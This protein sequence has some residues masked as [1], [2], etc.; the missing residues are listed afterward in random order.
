MAKKKSEG[1]GEMKRR[2]SA[3]PVPPMAEARVV[4]PAV[5]RRGGF[6]AIYDLLVWFA[7]F[8]VAQLCAAAVVMA[9]GLG[10]HEGGEPLSP[11]Q[12]GRM[13]ALS[14][15][16]SYVLALIFMLVYRRL[17]GGKG[18]LVR[19]SARGFDPLFL[20][21]GVVFMLAVGVVL[22]PL[23]ALLPA[24]PS[25]MYGTGF[26]TILS[27]VVLAPLFEE[28]ICRGV[29]LESLR[30]RFGVVGAW[31]LSSLFFGAIHLQPQL[32][33]NAL[34]MGMI[35]GYVVIRTGSLWSAILLHAINNS[36]AYVALAVGLDH[37]SLSDL[38]QDPT[39]YGLIYALCALI[40][41][42]SVT[43]AGRV[44][45]RLHRDEREKMAAAV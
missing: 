27:V 45:R 42:V 4:E 24:V 12:M 9:L 14:G 29:V 3:V 26:W 37:V 35:L 10:P 30:G 32:S 15:G 43:M 34:F 20:L 23:L 7:L 41:L 36:M 2:S 17:R 31:A 39:L 19:L 11:D 8:V 22:E 25:Q 40:T 33:V 18:R 6:P 1:K 5:R 38:V 44:L 13:L 16:I 28:L 21:W